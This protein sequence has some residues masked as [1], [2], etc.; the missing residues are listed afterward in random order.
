MTAVQATPEEQEIQEIML[1]MA[2]KDMDWSKLVPHKPKPYKHPDTEVSP[3]A[4]LL[5]IMAI[6]W[7]IGIFVIL[8]LF[9]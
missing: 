6:V 5:L 7:F 8:L 1:H 9:T 3:L 2:D 4:V